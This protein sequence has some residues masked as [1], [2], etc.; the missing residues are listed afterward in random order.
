[1]KTQYIIKESN[2]QN[3]KKFYNYI[4]NKYNLENKSPYTNEN[5]VNS[6]FPFVIDFKENTFWVCKS[7]TCCACSSKTMITINDFKNII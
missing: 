6:S 5:F 2:K 7:I 1:M 4:K 3:R